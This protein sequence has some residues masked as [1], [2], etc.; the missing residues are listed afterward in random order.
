MANVRLLKRDINNMIYDVV[1]ECYSLQLFDDSKKKKT[2]DFID[3]AAD[4]QEDI[5]SD[6]KKATS[7]KEYKEIQ[8]KVDKTAKEW[9]TKLNKLQS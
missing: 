7:K 1:E 6:V 3:E 2:D 9:V 8:E 5:M 4:F